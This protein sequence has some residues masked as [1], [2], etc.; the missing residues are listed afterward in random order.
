MAIS[1]FIVAR[2]AWIA[3]AWAAL[4]LIL[5]PKAPRVAE[6]LD[7]AARVDGSESEAV[8][9]L[10]AGT[11]ESRF[12]RFAI[13]VATGIPSPGT[14]QG[15]AVLRCIAERVRGAPGVAGVVSWLDEGDSLFLPPR[16][17]GSFLGVGLDAASTREDRIMPGLREVTESLTAELVVEYP[18]I[19][20]RWTGEAALNVDMRRA[21]GEAVA[22]A[23]QRALPLSA[24]LLLVAFGAIVATLIPV[25]VGA[26]A[27]VLSLGAAAA[28]GAW[29]PVSI[30]VQSVVSMLGLGLGIDYALLS[31]SRFREELAAGR[32]AEAAAV[33]TVRH[34][35]H[36]ILLS[37][38]T[39]AIGFGVLLIVPLNEVRGI[40]VGG[41]L[42]VSASAMLATTLLPGAL[43]WLGPRVDWGRLP[44]TKIR[45]TTAWWSR[46]GRWV[47]AHP[48]RALLLGA[49]PLAALTLQAVRLRTGLPRGNWLPS[50]LEST[51]ALDDLRA[52][53]RGNA[54][55]GI[56][57]V[58]ILPENASV[59]RSAGWNALGRLA[60]SLDTDRRVRRVHS[61]VDVA[62]EAGMGRTALAFL[63]DSLTGG[64]VTADGRVAL[65]EVLPED[66]LD[67]NGLMSFVRELRTQWNGRIGLPGARLQVGGL[68][69]FNADYRDA[70]A[71][72]FRPVVMLVVGTTL[73]SLL[74]GMRSILVAVK[75]V[76]LNL[77]SVAAAFGALTLVFQDGFGGQLLGVE[78][79]MGSV[80]S[81]LPVIVFCIVFGLSMDYEV[82]LVMRV[83]EARKAGKPEADAIVEALETTGGVITSAAAIML[84]V[85]AAFMW[86]DF[87]FIKLLGF[88]LAVAVL[89]DVTLVRMLVGPA[90]LSLAGRWNWWPDVEPGLRRSTG[91]PC[92]G[93]GRSAG[94]T[95]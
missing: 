66:S 35:G 21:S 55:Q 91:R 42:V 61:V 23:E 15:D 56:R 77:L 24:G 37:A 52:M 63:S 44:I 73:V 47:V 36:T 5:A 25:G 16:G 68:P 34:A 28:V 10:M 39:V 17:T 27:I 89:L 62:R 69:A 75:A 33:E 7:V 26:F 74:I 20:L 58:L 87:L 11:L 64:L 9:R 76:T 53:G 94:C 79:P 45:G 32:G 83:R 4:T 93:A 18:G 29:W 70:A 81:T 41:L 43:A 30:L 49:L 88:T 46:L 31:V 1:E 14:A 90:L 82:F 92:N 19:A 72:W 57:V 8:D 71:G 50:A 2:R 12:A 38:L 65:L 40:A 85:F 6:V 48:W 3:A 22:R 78:E 95:R 86:G 59:R 67:A 84:V 60:D 80:F 54:I 13:L 51:R